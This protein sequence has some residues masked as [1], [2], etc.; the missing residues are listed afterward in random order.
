MSDQRGINTRGIA[1]PTQ[2]A[3]SAFGLG[4]AALIMTI[5]GFVWLGWGF[6]VSSA[7]TQFSSGAVLPATRW[8]SFYA[9]FICLLGLSIRAL[10]KGKKRMKAQFVSPD[11]F[12]SRFGK[13]FKIISLVEG[14]GCGIAVLLALAFHRS[15]LV[16]TGI[17][18]VVGLHFLPMA[19]LFRFSPYYVSG[20]TIILSDLLSVLLLHGRSITFAVGVATGIVLWLMAVY[21][22]LC[23]RQFLRRSAV[24]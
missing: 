5:F 15:D 21:A 8:L 18:L 9:V 10:R 22:L 2:P 12:R 7:F 3:G 14:I 19:R 11:D 23:S 6:S 20:M 17:S 4:M 16:A 24:T 13:Q 1:D